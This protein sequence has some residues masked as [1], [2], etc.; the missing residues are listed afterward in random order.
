[1]SVEMGK[2][3][4][5]IMFL[6]A[7]VS[8]SAREDY[9]TLVD[10]AEFYIGGH[11]W[12]KA[13]NFIQRA[14]R[15]EPDNQNTSL[16]LS[17][18]ATVQRYQGRYQ[19]ALRNYTVA[20]FMTPNAVTLL[21]NRASLYLDMDSI[22]KAYSD[23]RKVV[24]L[25]GNDIEAL[26]NSG[27]L[28]L[29]K[30]QMEESEASFQRIKDI[31]PN[32]YFAYNGFA[33]WNKANGNYAKAIENYSVIIKERPSVNALANRAECYLE[34]KQLNNA[35]ADIKSALGTDPRNGF[36]YLLRAKL[37]KLRFE[38]DAA[39][40]DAEIAMEYGVEESV[41]RAFFNKD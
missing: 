15:V 7:A 23:Y 29:E 19:E 28:A 31:S 12:E 3:V 22:D 30:K 18:L 33:M 20:L 40:R 11:E 5:L 34:L 2:I 8:V 27:I 13:E 25:D 38:S 10:S 35:E 24:E 37:N 41:V 14:L 16:L 26:Y 21:K 1:M 39:R 6:L 4:T 17:N 9:Y 32:S 36:L